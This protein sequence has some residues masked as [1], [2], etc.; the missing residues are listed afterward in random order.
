MS[1]F[2]KVMIVLLTIAA[3]AAPAIAGTVFDKDGFKYTLSGDIQIQFDQ[4]GNDDDDMY[5]EYDDLEIKNKATYQIN[6]MMSVYGAFDFS[7][8]A[9]GDGDDS[10]IAFEEAHI[11]V[12]YNNFSFKYGHFD[13]QLDNFGV[14]AALENTFS[15][16]A[17]DYAYV[18]TGNGNSVEA[19]AAFDM[20]TVTVGHEMDSNDDDDEF[21][22]VNVS[23]SVAGLSVTA[24]YADNTADD[25]EAYGVSASYDFGVASVGAD[26]S[27]AS[28]DYDGE[29][30]CYNI[31][32]KAPVGE[33]AKVAVGFNSE[34]FEGDAADE[35]DKDEDTYNSFW[36]NGSYALA[37]GVNAFAELR[38][39]DNRDDM[40]YTAGLQVKF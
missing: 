20:V 25:L 19:A 8:N 9:A 16:D 37:S 28:D 38:N 1:K 12:S 4:N 35:F 24:A 3:F 15:A 11:G 2:L 23:F 14:E 32:V 40:A 17:F 13:N 10:D 27:N 30:T 39:S 36:I 29:V 5:I 21:T 6:D 7:G 31:V 33:K 18:A 26:Y 34:E 22:F